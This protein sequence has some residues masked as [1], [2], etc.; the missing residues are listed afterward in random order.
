MGNR[1][2]GRPRL[3]ITKK[4]SIT[5]GEEVWRVLELYAQ[6][7][8]LSKSEVHAKALKEYIRPS[9]FKID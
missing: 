4:V 2:P 1:K 8:G 6:K 5:M 9:L 3:G 7:H